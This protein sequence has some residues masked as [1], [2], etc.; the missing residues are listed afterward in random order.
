MSESASDN[1]AYR[2]PVS[3]KGIVVR[4]GA[5]V[6][7][8]NRR[9]EW[10][11]PGGKLELGESPER[12][13][14][15]EIEEE[16]ALDVEPSTLVDSWVY[17]ITPG[18]HVLVLTYGCTE[19]AT[20][21]AVLSREHTRLVWIALDEVVTLRMPEGYKTSIARYRQLAAIGRR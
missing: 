1:D 8:R 11:L 19:R 16:L 7:V 18:T 4:D 15:R 14:S 20:R 5:V 17:T 13:V 21:D 6:L 2:F 3:V 12:C 9:D 10:E